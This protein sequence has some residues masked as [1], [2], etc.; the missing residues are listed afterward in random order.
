VLN[1]LQARKVRLALRDRRVRR[2]RRAIRAIR[3]RWGPLVHRGILAL[4]DLVDLPGRKA[5][6][7]RKDQAAPATRA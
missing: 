6:R 2:D 4:R 7:V 1:D 3:V 5:S